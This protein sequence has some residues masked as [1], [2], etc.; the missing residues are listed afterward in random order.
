MLSV[1]ILNIKESI[2]SSIRDQIARGILR[3]NDL[4][5]S[6]TQLM[7]QFSVSRM[8]AHQALRELAA[9]GLVTRIRG[10]GTRVAQLYRLSSQLTLRDIKEDIES[11]GHTHSCKVIMLEST[12]APAQICVRLGLPPNSTVHHSLIIHLQ[13]QQPLQLEDRYVNPELAPHYAMQSFEQIT[14]TSYLMQ[15][16]PV[17]NADFHIEACM[18][19]LFEA[20]HLGITQTDPCLVM[21]RTTRSA[22]QG[23]STAK[24]LYPA[25]RYTFSGQFQ[26]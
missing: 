2:K 26:V 21:Y 7:L 12:I 22:G 19:E 4:V 8:T 11:K 6:E 16:V 23:A 1:T 3:S 14:P 24:L 9:D 10:S 17:T 13:D 25:S 15:H 20:E 18:P 5:P